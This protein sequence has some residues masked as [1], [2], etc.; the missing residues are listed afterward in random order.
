MTMAE[1]L[2]LRMEYTLLRKLEVPRQTTAALRACSQGQTAWA[3]ATPLHPG[4]S[5]AEIGTSWTD[6]DQSGF[7]DF[8]LGTQ[9][10]L[11]G[12]ELP[13]TA[14]RSGGLFAAPVRI[15]PEKVESTN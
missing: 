4:N 5:I 1:A 9:S 6:I 14:G 12:R 2:P 7:P 13:H 10:R 15:S 3:T 8:A 11:F